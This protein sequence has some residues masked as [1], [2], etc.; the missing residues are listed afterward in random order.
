VTE[1]ISRRNEF[2]L[3]LESHFTNSVWILVKIVDNSKHYIFSR[4]IKMKFDTKSFILGA[5]AVVLIILLWRFFT[6]KKSYFD[7][8][9]FASPM[10]ADEAGAAYQKAL[11]AI[12]S[13]TEAKAQAAIQAGNLDEAKKINLDAQRAQMELSLAYNTYVTSITPATVPI[14]EHP[15]PTPAPAPSP[16]M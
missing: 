1:V 11:D 5:L 4:I 7:V 2:V 12:N 9:T 14:P 15:M 10:T 3:G 8:P 16:S 6:A 13:E